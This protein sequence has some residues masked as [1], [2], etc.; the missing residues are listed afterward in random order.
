VKRDDEIEIVRA[1]LQHYATRGAFR[2]FSEVAGNGHTAE[3]HFLWFR[4]V[5]FRVMF[6]PVSRTLTFVD[7]LPA[8]GARSEMD[9]HLRAFVASRSQKLVPGHRRV[10]LKKVGVSVINRKGAISIV[11]ALKP[12]QVEYGAKKAVHL[13]HDILMDFLNEPQYVQYNIDHF[14]L[15]PEMA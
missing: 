9:R 2:S 5:K 13:V 1:L 3:F 11:F 14:H 12:R 7:I 6:N 4:D 10:D 15:N 8:V